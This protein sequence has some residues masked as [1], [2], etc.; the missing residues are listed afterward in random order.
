MTE[1]TKKE[2]RQP[3]YAAEKRCSL[4]LSEKELPE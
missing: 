4:R 3:M 1:R 2:K